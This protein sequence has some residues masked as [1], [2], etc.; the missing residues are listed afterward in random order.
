MKASEACKEIV[1]VNDRYNEEERKLE[2]TRASVSEG[3]RKSLKVYCLEMIDKGHCVR[4]EKEFNLND[5][6]ETWIV[7]AGE[8]S[9]EFIKPNHIQGCRIGSIKHAPVAQDGELPEPVDQT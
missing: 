6:S 7:W 3:H 9:I 1:H 8:F 4:L 2:I 5:A